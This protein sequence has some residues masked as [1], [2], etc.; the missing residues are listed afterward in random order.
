MTSIGKRRMTG[1][2][3]IPVL[4]II[5]FLTM[6]F[7]FFANSPPR[8][9]LF[10]G[11]ILGPREETENNS[12][13]DFRIFS[14]K[15]SSANHMLILLMPEDDS[16]TADELIAFYAGNFKKQGFRFSTDGTR[17]LGLRDDEAIYL[18]TA[19]NLE[20]AIAYI[21]KGAKPAPSKLDDADSLYLALES[22]SFD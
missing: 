9:I 14:Y 3:A 16:V 11:H 7:I 10:Q 18:T 17:Q 1:K 4:I 15:D 22:F 13:K 12:N 2:A 8:E 6:Y 21:E 19:A 20:S 5:A